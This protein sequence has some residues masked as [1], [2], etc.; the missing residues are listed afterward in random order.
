MASIPPPSGWAGQTREGAA[1]APL[2]AAGIGK[3]KQEWRRFAQQPPGRR[4]RERHE[5]RKDKSRQRPWWRRALNLLL[6][7]VLFAIG[8]FLAVAPGPAVLFF[9]PA[10][11]L[12]A[13]EFFWAAALLDALD[14]LIT[15]AL[16]R[17]HRRWCR[18][19][20]AV[21]RGAAISLTC[22]S[23]ALLVGGWWF[24]FLR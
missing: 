2:M 21:R 24:F 14:R 7:A 3:W 8:A 22:G 17:F 19:S 23:L 1:G 20:P 5:R 4:F 12:L 16:Q 10:G 11:V 15:P 18:L 6:A 13:S 9:V